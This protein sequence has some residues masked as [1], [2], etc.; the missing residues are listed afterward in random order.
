MLLFFSIL[1][2]VFDITTAGIRKNKRKL[3][4]KFPSDKN[5]LTAI[6]ILGFTNFFLRLKFPVSGNIVHL[7]FGLAP[8]YVFLFTLGIFSSYNKWFEAITSAKAR[9]WFG[10][11]I[12]AILAWPL[13]IIINGNSV[14]E[15]EIFLGGLRWQSFAYAFWE[16]VLSIS[17]PVWIIYLFRKKFDFQN[18]LFNS[19]SKSAYTVFLIHPIVL[20][21]LSYLL[22]NIPLH[23]LVKFLIVGLA[24]TAVCF[25]LGFL[26]TRIRFLKNIL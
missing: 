10:A 18:K 4:L 5:I 8:Q 17:M 15:M 2:A 26:I 14:P 16:A 12:A 1:Y 6:I 22:K 23:P 13:F 7:N 24:G 19:A 9:L 11:S 25:L 21:A 3:I 20:V